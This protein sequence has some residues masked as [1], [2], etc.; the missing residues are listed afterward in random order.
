MNELIFGVYEKTTW[1]L[2]ENIEGGQEMKDQVQ[3]FSSL[4]NT[5]ITVSIFLS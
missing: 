3:T 1:V 5:N 2:D 4:P